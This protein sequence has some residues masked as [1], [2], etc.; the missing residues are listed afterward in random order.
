[1][2]LR[3]DTVKQVSEFP[4]D[5]ESTRGIRHLTLRSGRVARERVGLV[6]ES[7]KG[8]VVRGA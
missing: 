8:N 7:Q 4:V 5:G 6:D 2:L 1:M 3:E